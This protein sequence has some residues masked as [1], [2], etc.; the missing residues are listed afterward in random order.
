MQDSPLGIRF[1]DY[2]SAFSSGQTVAASFDRNLLYQRGLALGA[3]HK[4][5][6]VNV[7]YNHENSLAPSY[8]C[9]T[10]KLQDVSAISIM[11]AVSGSW[12]DAY[13]TL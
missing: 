2:A 9:K 5:K 3:E 7:S 11:R 6:G 10:L 4:G 12:F 13:G 8:I 1:A